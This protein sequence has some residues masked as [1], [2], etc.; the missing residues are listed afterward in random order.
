MP[1][2]GIK[3]RAVVDAVES[4]FANTRRM[5][6]ASIPIALGT[7]SGTCFNLW[8]AAVIVELRRLMATGMTAPEALVVATQG[9]A[10]ALNLHDALGKI[11]PGYRADL[12]VVDGQ[13]DQDPGDLIKTKHVIIDGVEQ[14]MDEPGWLDVALLGLRILW[15]KLRG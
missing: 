7:D 2:P 12:I 8:G 6:E 14:R 5:R 9:S 1:M 4:N 13:P 3:R 11:A 10:R 15:D